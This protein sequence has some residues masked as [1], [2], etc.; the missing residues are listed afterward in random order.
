MNLRFDTKIEL[1]AIMVSSNLLTAIGQYLFKFALIGT[2]I[3]LLSLLCGIILYCF[4]SLA[5][6][7]VLSKA[8]LSWA[9]GVGGV[10]YIFAV[11]LAIILLGETVTV[12]NWAG[13]ALIVVGT[14]LIGFS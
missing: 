6:L 8:R 10:R 1:F 7:Y 5:Y 3:N 9:F 13:V 2:H 11:V 14:A 12:I 4:S